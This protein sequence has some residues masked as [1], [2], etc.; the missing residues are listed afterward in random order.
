M[1]DRISARRNLSKSLPEKLRATWPPVPGAGPI[2]TAQRDLAEEAATR[3]EVLEAAYGEIGPLLDR[4]HKISSRRGW[5]LGR[6]ILEC[7]VDELE[8]LTPTTTH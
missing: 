4:L 6:H 7:A 1:T 8:R 5:P 3:I 2:T